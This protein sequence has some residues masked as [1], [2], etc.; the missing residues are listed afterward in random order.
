MDHVF[1]AVQVKDFQCLDGGLINTNLKVD[2]AA[3]RPPVVLRFY[4]DGAAVCRKEVG[5]LRLVSQTVPVAKVLHSEPDGFAGFGAHAILEFVEGITF[6]QL[7]R[8]SDL[9]AIQ[10]ASYSVGTTLAAIG[11]YQFPA[12][13]RLTG[14]AYS[15]QV[16][17]Q[18]V[19]GPNPIASIMDVF[20][21]SPN[22]AGRAGAALRQKL[23]DFVWA[24]EARMP[25][26]NNDHSLVHSDFG[27]R[28][29]LVRQLRGE[30]QVAAVLD[31][32]FAFSG[33]PLLDVGHFLRYERK[34]QPLREPHFSRGF[35]EQGGSLPD[36]WRKIARVI[37]LTGLVECLTHEKL[38][39]QVETELLQLIR[40][41]LTECDPS[42][43]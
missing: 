18:Y 25:G 5:V 30:W 28:N 42:E 9:A 26:I 43:T 21:A 4:R 10:Q 40:A 6:Q 11:R 7:K 27:N 39:P 33:T 22:L 15:L 16:G 41:T 2:L 34:E 20:L 32:E 19:T 35:V 23:H 12:A 13:G 24:W 17:E 8:S 29:V 14:E 3:D 36:N 31:W 1:P 38:P 37:D